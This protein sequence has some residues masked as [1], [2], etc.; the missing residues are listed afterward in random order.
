[1]ARKSKSKYSELRFAMIPSEVLTSEACKSLP[2][3]AFRCLMALTAANRT[4]ARAEERAK[5]P[6]NNGDLSLSVADARKQFGIQPA[7]RVTA[8]LQMC[9]HARL[10]EITRVGRVQ[11]GK[12]IAQ[13]YGLCW[14]PVA[15]SDKY[16]SPKMIPRSAANEWINWKRPADWAEIEKRIRQTAQGTKK[17]DSRRLVRKGGFHTSRLGRSRTRRLERNEQ[18]AVQ[19]V[20]NPS[21]ISA[22]ASNASGSPPAPASLP[23]PFPKTARSQI[24]ELNVRMGKARK[25]LAAAPGTDNA[26]VMQ[27]YQLTDE[28]VQ[29]LK[30]SA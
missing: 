24:R 5:H 19:G 29:Q 3:Y 14:L 11:N 9:R 18:S 7:W 25:L 30:A 23:D 22:G 17:S 28:Q 10:V 8:G 21:E 15:P 20:L 26:K 12:G 1:L 6:G 27:L 16:D 13:L 2:D 4:S